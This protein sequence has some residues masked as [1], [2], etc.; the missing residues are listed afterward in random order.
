MGEGR[1]WS[2]LYVRTLSLIRIDSERTVR[3]NRESFLN[4]CAR[5][6]GP[7]AFRA[8][9]G[10][11][12]ELCSAFSTVRLPTVS[13]IFGSEP[14]FVFFFILVQQSIRLTF[15][16][17][18]RDS[19]EKSP[20]IPRRVFGLQNLRVFRLFRSTRHRLRTRYHTEGMDHPIVTSS[21]V[22]SE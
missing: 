10:R 14:R 18:D 21:T 16:A 6:S 15:F 5:S 4:I 11:R 22:S 13:L 12:G 1:P 9:A 8:I 3:Q 19:D 2:S 20:R 17:S 7:L